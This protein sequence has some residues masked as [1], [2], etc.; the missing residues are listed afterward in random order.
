MDFVQ[1]WLFCLLVHERRTWGH[2]SP[3]VIQVGVS[4][5]L[6]RI[7]I[8]GTIFFSGTQ[9]SLEKLKTGNWVGFLRVCWL[10]VL[11]E[12]LCVSAMWIPRPGAYD[13]Q[14]ILRVGDVFS[15]LWKGLKVSLRDILPLPS[16][17]EFPRV[18]LGRS[19]KFRFWSVLSGPFKIW[20]SDDSGGSPVD[21]RLLFGALPP[22]HVVLFDHLRNLSPIL[23][24][25][26]AQ[27][28]V[29]VHFLRRGRTL[30]DLL[31]YRIA[32]LR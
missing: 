4:L 25:F 29:V 7:C 19:L 1:A 28:E 22:C 14:L 6:L 24:V 30:H 8:L 32:M 13:R 2:F 31:P 27:I 26:W 23:V 16:T 20:S 9:K 12:I 5:L 11:H 15:S 21:K 17:L 18:W 3:V 10:W